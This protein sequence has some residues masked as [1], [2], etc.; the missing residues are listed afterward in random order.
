[1]RDSAKSTTP[2]IKFKQGQF[3]LYRDPEMFW[4]GQAGHTFVCRVQRSWMEG[5]YDLVAV[6]TGR[7]VHEASGDYMRLLPA[8]DADARHR[9]R[10]AEHRRRGRRHDRGRHR[11][12]GPS[13]TR[14]PTSV[15]SCPPS[16]TD[17]TT[18]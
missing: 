18:P 15:R 9:H 14:P 3:V 13:S 8:V 4:T 7:F 17:R 6:A 5:T 10:A 1:M 16:A 11:L 12:A 2:A